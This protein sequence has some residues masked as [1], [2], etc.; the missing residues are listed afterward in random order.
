[1]LLAQSLVAIRQRVNMQS[2]LFYLACFLRY[3]RK[4]V[5]LLKG[6]RRLLLN[7]HRCCKLPTDLL[8]G[9]QRLPR[10]QP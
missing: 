3:F 5:N 6:L 1:V 7:L 4:V 2:Q 8:L 9:L 10:R